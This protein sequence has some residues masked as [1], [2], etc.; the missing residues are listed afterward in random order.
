MTIYVSKLDQVTS[1]EN[2]RR[3]D[4]KNKKY[5]IFDGNRAANPPS[6]RRSATRTQET[7]I[8][9][10]RDMD[11]VGLTQHHHQHY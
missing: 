10:G 7:K 9:T 2:K 1:E 6:L 3:K 8:Q 11:L 4:Q 5:Y